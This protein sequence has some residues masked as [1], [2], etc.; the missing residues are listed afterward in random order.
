M[1]FIALKSHVTI[2]SQYYA[3]NITNESST[4]KSYNHPSSLHMLFLKAIDQIEEILQLSDSDFLLEECKSVLASEIHRINLFSTTCINILDDYNNPVL[5]LRYLSFLF[6][7]SNHSILRALL[8]FTSKAIHLLDEFDS[9][10]DPF[11]IIVSY[12]IPRF[13]SDMILSRTSEYTLLAI[14]CNKE[15][16]QCSLQYVLYVQSFIVEKCDIT[17]HCLQLLAVNSD[18][19]IFYWTIPKCVVELIESNVLQHSEYLYSQGII[20]VLVY[21][22]RSLATGD[23][24][25]VG[26]LAFTTEKEIAVKRLKV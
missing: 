11:N 2:E 13:S 10:L 1:C 22:K 21:P 4:V 20:E 26:S 25:M 8:S 5:I 9:L 7:W 15:L 19:T 17:Q 3:L 24:I 23:D 18:P 12:P 14:R 16:W 6:T